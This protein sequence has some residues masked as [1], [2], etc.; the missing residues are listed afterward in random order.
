MMDRIPTNYGWSKERAVD[1]L[2]ISDPGFAEVLIGICVVG[3]RGMMLGYMGYI[4]RPVAILLEEAHLT[5]T[6]MG[7]LL[8]AVAT[9]QIAFGLTCYFRTR[10]FISFCSALCCLAIWIAY[11]G[12][13]KEQT[14]MAWMW[15]GLFIAEVIL[16]FRVL[17]TRIASLEKE[18]KKFKSELS[19]SSAVPA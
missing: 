16:S 17:M 3:I 2:L 18:S 6:V 5:A 4:Y 11:L 19:S 1:V 12:A 7:S 14:A 10:S 13:G 15:F 8:V 9:L